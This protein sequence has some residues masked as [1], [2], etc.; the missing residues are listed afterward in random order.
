M[1]SL[2][3]AIKLLMDFSILQSRILK[4][5]ESQLSVHGLSFSEFMVMHQLMQ[6]PKNTLRRIDLAEQIGLSASGVTRML[7]PMEKRKLV[8][9]Q[10]NSRDARVSLV[11]LTSAGKQLYAD[12][13]S[14]YE[15]S[16]AAITQALGKPQLE[17]MS[18][19]IEKLM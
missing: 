6:A 13:L 1:P 2:T 14:A 7:M 4:R 3:P 12:A 11:Q 15:H 8:K 19:F 18:A 17:Q 9:R 5:V 10:V 16:A